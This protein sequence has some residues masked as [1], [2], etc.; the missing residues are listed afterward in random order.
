MKTDD[1]DYDTKK[2]IIYKLIKFFSVH[3]DERVSKNNK[4]TNSYIYGLEDI[5]S[6]SNRMINSFI[7]STEN[8][9]TLN[10]KS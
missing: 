5:V 6:P 8:G 9:K 10:V 4:L 1:F 2:S 7:E 3:D